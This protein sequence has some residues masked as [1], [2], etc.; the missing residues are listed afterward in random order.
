VHRDRALQAGNAAARRWE[1]LSP[2][3]R[4]TAPDDELLAMSLHRERGAMV[5]ADVCE[6]PDET[7]AERRALLREAN[8][9][10]VEQV[11]GYFARPWATGDSEVAAVAAGPALA[12]AHR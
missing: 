7:G 3:D 5:V 12:P 8:L 9:A 6:L 10:I 11:R 1:D 4:A 2:A